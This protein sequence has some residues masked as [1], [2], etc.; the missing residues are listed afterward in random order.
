[1]ELTVF[2]PTYNRRHTLTRTYKS[3][4]RQTCK[5]FEWIVID[6]GSTD[7]VDELV[8]KWIQRSDENGF[9]I[10][11]YRKENGGLHTAYNE[12]IKHLDS[13]LA[14]CID[15][16]DYMP[17][18]AV[19]K[20]IN[21]WREKGRDKYGGII[22]L[23]IKES[24]EVI[25]GVLPNQESINLISLAT[26]KLKIKKGDKKIVVRSDL[27][28]SV[29]P[30]KVFPGEKNFN[31]H[32]MHLEISRKYDFLVLNEPI[33]IVDYQSNGM[34]ASQFKQYRNSPNSFLE[35]RKQKLSFGKLPL[36]YEAKTYMHMI[37]SAILSKRVKEIIAV[38]PNKLLLI[39]MFP[40]GI[41]FSIVVLVKGR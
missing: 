29:A 12:A 14:V 21:C 8:K 19:E 38:A 4:C 22:G 24:G 16:D 20:I 34:T 35:L 2:T 7:S 33:C 27:Y 41:L 36:L 32:Y 25:G 11:Y 17:D 39:T 1:M 40:L 23:D 31:P 26:G 6:D 5:E 37:S 3:L 9:V 18:D 10:K 30:M 13:E 28:K 15:S